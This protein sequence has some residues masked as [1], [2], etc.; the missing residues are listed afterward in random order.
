MKIGN[1]S[2]LQRHLGLMA[3]AAVLV[4]CIYYIAD[5]SLKVVSADLDKYAR[6]SE[7][8]MAMNE[9]VNQSTLSLIGA[10]RAY[11]ATPGEANYANVLKG[12]DTARKGLD[13]I[14]K[15][16]VH[17]PE[18]EKQAG[19]IGPQLEAI[20]R[21]T[22]SFKGIHEER[23]K[24]VSEAD[25]I[26][27]GVIADLEKVMEENIDPAKSQAGILADVGEMIRWGDIDMLMNEAVIANTL[28]LK[29]AIHDY[30]YD[31]VPAKFDSF[32]KVLGTAR[33]G[34]GKWAQVINDEAALEGTAAAVSKAYDALQGL[35]DR[36]DKISQTVA[37]LNAEM[38]KSAQ[39]VAETTAAIME[40]GID[41]AKAETL[42]EAKLVKSESIYFLLAVCGIALVLLM[43]GFVSLALYES[44]I[45]RRLTA[46][47]ELVAKGDFSGDFKLDQQDE[48]G[49]ISGALNRIKES[50]SSALDKN[51][52]I[53]HEAECGKF[54][55]RGEASMFR[56]AY[57][58]LIDSSNTLMDIFE[59]LL[60][61]LP[62]G[63]MSRSLRREILYLN[64]FAKNLSG[65]T[66]VDGQRCDRIFNTDDCKG[67]CASERSLESGKVEA[68]DT[69]CRVAGKEMDITYS[70]IPLISRAGER[71]GVFEV[72]LDQT[73][74]RRAYREMIQMSEK[75]EVI[76]ER[77]SSASEE[78]AAQIEEVAKGSEVQR[79]RLNETAGAM[80]QMSSTVLDV[81]RS[82]SAASGQ[83]DN[84]R[85]M[86]G[87]GEVLVGK[88]VEGIDQVN[89]VATTLQRNIEG[90]GKKAEDIGSIMTVITDIAD[91]TNL[92]ALNAAIEAARAGEAGRGF[93]VVADE[94]R[95]LAEKTM[96]ATTEV[97]SSIKEIQAAAETSVRDVNEAVQKVAEATGLANESGTALSQIVALSSE[98]SSI[99]SGIATA[100]EQQSSTAEQI[101]S[102]VEEVTHVASE[103]ADGMSQSASAIQEL[104]VM[105]GDLK[106]VIE[107]LKNV[108]S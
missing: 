65:I 75:A 59:S 100:A 17:N 18:L 55:V 98:S 21:I 97:G 51:E 14:R 93:A 70:G 61:S 58:R 34:L 48:L 105:A 11:T 52:Q 99:I 20:G 7:I 104:A 16:L 96:A 24:L 2:I 15:M 6:W 40:S 1:M 87:K 102:A 13:G 41:P 39:A 60:N 68:G 90:L 23:T 44:R 53:I 82:A 85:N 106:V 31:P 46:A 22:A 30:A 32:G 33:E 84:A 91:Q 103:T 10:V 94:V 81:A 79:M 95:K 4:I 8:D 50:I 107:R 42:A 73:D 12:M 19:E 49:Q 62:V 25:G 108:K 9:D 72:I 101:N 74:I 37:G 29:I 57:A 26:I 35:F 86:A 67:N 43:A 28:K 27:A 66:K 92:L 47:A 88:V 5:H 89:I 69:I 80:E 77:L 3:F 45:L 36:L 54:D 78:L 63:V 71:R 83:S 56:G 64:S 38:D 76:S